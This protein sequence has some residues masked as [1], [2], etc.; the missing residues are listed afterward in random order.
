MRILIL[1][2]RYPPDF[3]Q[4]G[5]IVSVVAKALV[6]RGHHVTCIVRTDSRLSD[7]EVIDGVDVVRVRES[8]FM[9]F[10]LHGDENKNS[11][12]WRVIRRMLVYLR[13]GV[14]LFFMFG[15]PNVE[16]LM[17]RKMSKVARRL[18]KEERY[19]CA[20]GVF[21]P[22]SAV[23]AA[24]KLKNTFPNIVCGAYYLDLLS[25]QPTPS[26]LPRKLFD[27]LAYRG[28]M[29]AFSGLDFVLMAKGGH[30]QYS[31]VQYSS[32]AS[33]IH[34][35]DFP[36]FS[37]VK[38]EHSDVKEEVDTEVRFLYAGTLVKSFRNPQH[39]LELIEALSKEVDNVSMHFYSGG[40]CKDVINQFSQ[41]ASFKIVQHGL[42]SHSEVM[43]AMMKADY[44]VNIS[45]R[46]ENMVPSKIF[47]LFST[48]KPIINLVKSSDD[49]ANSYFKKY[50]Y[51]LTL[52]E[53][54]VVT[55]NSS[56]L[57]QFMSSESLV[58]KG[59][60]DL[61]ALFYEN[62]P[63][64]TATKIEEICSFVKQDEGD[65]RFRKARRRR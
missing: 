34:F 60:I 39:L 64:Y 5:R 47:E 14:M 37:V 41:N 4:N 40:D 25:G 19:D 65:K 51:S 27:R 57:Q 20:I 45:N 22:F 46:S 33:K 16:P 21:R 38:Q 35:I 11:I 48:G 29:L 50:P 52:C 36:T 2:G 61:E 8:G 59:T 13:K 10:I 23:S 3:S 32:V 24:C 9:K 12:T 56:L 62:T 42:V 55:E 26:L 44:L 15:F 6:D 49:Y 17:S 28:E 18:Q 7:R 53:S 58:E 63:G 30:E 54:D 31:Q 1:N 43:S